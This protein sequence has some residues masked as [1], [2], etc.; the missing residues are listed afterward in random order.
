MSKKKPSK[1]SVVE[2]TTT[3]A[4]KRDS[5]VKHWCF[6]IN[7]P[8]KH[9]KD[10]P[11]KALEGVYH[12]L[13]VGKE[14]GEQGT[15]HYQCYVI[16]KQKM[17]LTAL[18]KLLPRAHLVQSRG[19]AQ[20]ASDSCKK[21]GKFTED[22]VLP[23]SGAELGGQANAQKWERIH[24]LAKSAT[25]ID[26]D[27]AIALF[28]EEFPHESF[29]F[30]DKFQ[31]LIDHYRAP[32]ITMDEIDARWYV[33]PSGS[34]KSSTARNEFPSYYL[35]D[36]R[37]KWFDGY[38]HQETVLVDEV[39]KDA[40]YML[41]YLKTWADHYPFRGERKGGHTTLIRP[42]RIIVTTQYHWD[43]MTLDPELRAAIARRF[44][45]RW[46]PNGSVQPRVEEVDDYEGFA[47]QFPDCV[48]DCYSPGMER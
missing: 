20:Q 29:L 41:E 40:S 46:F 9:G 28:Y 44:K 14:V 30:A 24:Q 31:K 48:D 8:D 27:T 18:K 34:G 42:K 37:N 17:R 39:G 4:N 25:A 33:G 43:E 32:A 23:L 22:G 13:V 3:T 7:N 10:D 11:F 5:A 45:I 47:L 35:K 12:Y 36:S 21:D 6:T 1:A 2:S 19:T 16:L 15:P 26:K 38:D